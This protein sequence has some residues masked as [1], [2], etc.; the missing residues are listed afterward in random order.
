VLA[1]R[2]IGG[3]GSVRLCSTLLALLAALLL[4]PF[5]LLAFLA[6]LLL[7]APTAGETPYEALR[8]VC[9]PSYGVLSSL[10]GLPGLVGHL[11]C[12]ILCSSALLLLLRASGLR[13][14]GA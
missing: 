4:V 5:L 7:L 8:L 11:A 3:L 1:P 2:G 10:D 6:L 9:Y 12:G 13:L 14:R